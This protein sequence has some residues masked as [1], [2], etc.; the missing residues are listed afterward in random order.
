MTSPILS[1]SP[2]HQHLLTGLL[3]YWMVTFPQIPS[4]IFLQFPKKVSIYFCPS[5]NTFQ[6]ETLFFLM[7]SD[8]MCLFSGNVYK[9]K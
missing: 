9:V 5:V 8:I 6:K 3:V 2:F 4:K 7:K 1:L